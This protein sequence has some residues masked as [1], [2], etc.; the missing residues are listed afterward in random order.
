MGACL[1]SLDCC[2]ELGPDDD[3]GLGHTEA[4]VKKMQDSN[5]AHA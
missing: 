1:W 5:A 4:Q 2:C 3:M